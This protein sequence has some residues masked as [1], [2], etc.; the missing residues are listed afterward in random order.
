MK[1]FQ[2]DSTKIPRIMEVWSRFLVEL[3]AVIFLILKFVED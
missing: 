1:N 2:I 3:Q